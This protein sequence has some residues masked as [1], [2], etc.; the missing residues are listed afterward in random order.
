MFPLP[1]I[2]EYETLENQVNNIM[3]RVGNFFSWKITFQFEVNNSCHF[4]SWVI[5]REFS[6]KCSLAEVGRI[7]QKYA[8]LGG[9]NI[10]C[11]TPHVHH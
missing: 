8:E 9:T 4:V 6:W 10:P 2:R 11:S 7:G 3:L 5:N 1:V